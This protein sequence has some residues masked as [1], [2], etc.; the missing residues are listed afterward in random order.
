MRKLV[1]G[2][3]FL[4][5]VLVVRAAMA[6]VST[7]PYVV[8]ALTV[9]LFLALV[10][11]MVTLPALLLSAAIRRFFNHRDDWFDE[12]ETPRYVLPGVEN[13]AKLRR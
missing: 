9:V 13:P 2:A 12:P 4:I 8:G 7:S 6:G 1:A 10:C 5:T 11:F 3:T